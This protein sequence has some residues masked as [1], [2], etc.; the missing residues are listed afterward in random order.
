M[1]DRIK[2]GSP[3]PHVLLWLQDSAKSHPLLV[4]PWTVNKPQQARATVQYTRF[5]HPIVPDETMTWCNPLHLQLRDYWTWHQAQPFQ[6]TRIQQGE[7]KV[8]IKSTLWIDSTGLSP[9]NFVDKSIW[10]SFPHKHQSMIGMT[11]PPRSKHGNKKKVLVRKT[12]LRQKNRKV[13]G[14]SSFSFDVLQFLLVFSTLR[15]ETRIDM[16]REFAGDWLSILNGVDGVEKK[17]RV[18]L[19]FGVEELR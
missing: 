19:R 2:L 3:R 18:V 17:T 1:N 14:E 7:T 15:T 5:E 10:I 8:T 12:P 6:I 16:S 13:P 4:N 11:I 9:R